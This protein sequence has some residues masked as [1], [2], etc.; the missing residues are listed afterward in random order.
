MPRLWITG[1][2]LLSLALTAG[3]YEKPVNEAYKEAQERTADKPKKATEEEGP[4][5]FDRQVS[6]AGLKGDPIAGG[7][8]N[9]FFP[10]QEGD[11]DRVAKQEKAGFALYEMRKGGETL[12]ELSITDMR[13]DP[14]GVEKYQTTKDKV[15]TYW[16][17]KDGEK[18]TAIL[19]GDRFQ[20][21]VRS[22]GGQLDE[23]ARIEWIKKFD[24]A[25]LAKLDKE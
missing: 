9:Q 19:V 11:Y 13:N 1:T 2:L 4:P 7:E 25:G 18:G 20:V 24:L 8:L 12:A 21:K 10:P 5:A 15:D 6:T 22:P 17:V 16:K 14:K 3:C 23:A